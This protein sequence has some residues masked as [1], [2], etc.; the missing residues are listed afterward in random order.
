MGAVLIPMNAKR[1]PGIGVAI[2]LLRCYLRSDT[3][4]RWAAFG[5]ALFLSVCTLLALVGACTAEV[6]RESGARG[7]RDE[8]DF[9]FVEYRRVP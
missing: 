6:S 7:P 5:K 1:L 3:A 8:A 9:A 4:F 2:F